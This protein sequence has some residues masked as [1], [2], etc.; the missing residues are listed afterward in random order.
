V[1]ITCVQHLSQNT[2]MG[3]VGMSTLGVPL[4]FCMF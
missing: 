2:I 4:N 1:C 3:C